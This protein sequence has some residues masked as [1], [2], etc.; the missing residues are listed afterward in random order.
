[1][2]KNAFDDQ[3]DAGAKY[4]IKVGNANE[5]E[6]AIEQGQAVTLTGNITVDQIPL[7]EEG[8]TNIDLNGHELTSSEYASLTVASGAELN[9]SWRNPVDWRR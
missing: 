3:Y 8:A 4:A 5:L 2:R 6:E 7:N 9:I 1:M